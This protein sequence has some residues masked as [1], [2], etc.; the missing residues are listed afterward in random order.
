MNVKKS[1]KIVVLA[2]GGTIAGMANDV[3]QPDHYKAGVLPVST[4]LDGLSEGFVETNALTVE[5][6]QI[7]QIDS[8]DMDA[9][10]WMVLAARLL[11]WLDQADV[12]GVVITHGSDTL[13]ETAYFLQAV[14]QP[15]KP[16]V[17]TC[18]MR[19]ANAPDSDGS[20][21][22]QDAL[23][24][25]AQSD[26]QGVLVTCGGSVHAG[27]LVQ[28]IQSHDP[29]PF[30]SEL[31]LVARMVAG[32]LH[33]LRPMPPASYAWPMPTPQEVLQAKTWPRVE[34]VFN[35]AGAHG[36]N[37]QDMMRSNHPPQGFV[38]AGTGNGTVHHDLEAV[39]KEAQTQGVRVVRATRCALGHVSALPDDVLASAPGLTPAQARVGLQLA[40]LKQG[41]AK[42]G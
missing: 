34:L 40:L 9:S 21:N 8:K 36:E 35:H 20:A 22:L 16:V 39:L 41:L 25:A 29:R 6:E 14:F 7:A 4:L 18:A 1:K 38:V 5:A 26:L 33:A 10:I 17:L 19:A 42:A 37:V 13:E 28:K 3:L 27:H 24:L 30:V 23:L 15:T 12:H 11:H 32:K 31:G 2:T